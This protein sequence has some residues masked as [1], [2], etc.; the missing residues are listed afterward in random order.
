VR[1][2]ATVRV[3]GLQ[4]QAQKS[5]YAFDGAFGEHATTREIYDKFFV[6]RR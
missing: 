5:F 3:T 4:A 2:F 1:D 6:R